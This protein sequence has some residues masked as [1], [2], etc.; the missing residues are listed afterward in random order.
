[1]I[2]EVDRGSWCVSAQLP[3]TDNCKNAVVYFPHAI[4]SV[5]YRKIL[6]RKYRTICIV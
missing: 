1:M 2:S 3:C 4:Y 5:Y 6:Y